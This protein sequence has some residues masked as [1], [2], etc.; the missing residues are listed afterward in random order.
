MVKV[1]T[2]HSKNPNFINPKSIIKVTLK[3]VNTLVTL[4]NKHT[5]S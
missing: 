1:K 2:K 3:S 5:L 4:D